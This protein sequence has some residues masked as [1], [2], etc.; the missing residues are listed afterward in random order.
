MQ[1]WTRIVVDAVSPDIVCESVEGE[2]GTAGDAGLNGSYRAKPP[3][4][5]PQYQRKTCKIIVWL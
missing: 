4:N 5:S 1:S 3:H 2:E